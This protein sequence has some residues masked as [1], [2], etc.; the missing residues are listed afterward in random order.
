ML[1]NIVFS[2]TYQCPIKCRYCGAECGPE[3]T[4]RLSLREMTDII[5]KV[6]TYGKLELVVFTG[7]EPFLLG[8]DL[9]NGV[10]YCTEKGLITRIVTNAFWAKSPEIAKKTMRTYKDAGLTE[11]NLSCDD[12]HQEF[13]PLDNIK[14]ANE[15]CIGVGLPCLIGHKMMKNYS[16]TLDSIEN[17]LGCKLTY[18]DPKKKNPDNNVISTGYTVPIAE[19]MHLIP[20]EEILYPNDDHCWKGPCTSL[21]QRIIITP[22][23]E[24]SVCCGMVPR[25]VEEITFGTLD[26]YSLEE[27]IVMA[28]KDLIVNW[29]AL[30]GPYGIMKYIQEKNPHISFRQRYVNI[31]HLCS[32]VFTR[33]ECREV[34]LEH[35]Q[36]KVMEISL[37]RTLYDF[38]RTSEEIQKKIKLHKKSKKQTAEQ[39][40]Q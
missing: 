39:G 28:H 29:L 4:E 35:A 17:F 6:Y 25:K 7:G 30:E 18:F 3:R 10:K 8:K 26:E 40:K 27:L 23:K 19:D 20:D 14:N 11:I 13:I 2:T 12:Y 9:L 33:V 22:R 15:A 5:D 38:M 36:E 1:S 21:L 31:C 34:L 16:L 24:L 37:E 32:E